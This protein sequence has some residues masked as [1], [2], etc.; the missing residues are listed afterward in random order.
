MPK[1]LRAQGSATR[2][3]GGVMRVEFDRDVV[4]CLPLQVEAGGTILVHDFVVAGEVGVVAARVDEVGH[5]AMGIDDG[6]NGVRTIVEPGTEGV[7]LI[8]VLVEGIGVVRGGDQRID[9]A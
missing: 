4:R 7:R 5:G 3:G 6:A 8:P 2:I 9:R 1:L